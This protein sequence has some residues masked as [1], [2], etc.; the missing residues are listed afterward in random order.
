MPSFKKLTA[1]IAAAALN[2]TALFSLSSCGGSDGDDGKKGL[3]GWFT[4]VISSSPATLDPQTCTGD[5]A[6]Q[7]IANVFCGL[8]RRDDGGKVV[9][10]MAEKVSVSDDGLVYTFKLSENVKWYGKDD[11]SAECTAEDF[12]FAFRRLV[13]PAMRSVRASEYYCIK[14]AKEINTGK[15]TDLTQLGIEA[16]GKFEL[17]ITLCEPCSSLEQLLSAAPAMPCN[18]AYYELTEGQYGLV[19]DCIGSNGYFYVSRWHYDKW[20]K[21][22]NFIEL[23][24][25]PFNAEALETA[26]RGVTLMINVNGYESFLDGKTDVYCTAVPDEITRLSGR[27]AESPCPESVWGVVFNTRGA[28]ESTDL[29]IALGSF[30][31]GEFEGIYSSADCIVPDNASAGEYRSAAG[32][33]VKAQYSESELLE[34]GTRAVRELGDSA[35]TGMKLLIPEGTALRQGIGAVIQQW[36]KNFGV[37]CLIDEVPYPE[38]I[39]ALESGS[40][41]AAMVRLGGSDALTFLSAFSSTSQKNYGGVSSRKLDDILTGAHTAKDSGSAARYLLEAEQLILDSGWF[42]PL[43]FET[44]HIFVSSGVSGIVYDPSF[45]GYI[46]GRAVKK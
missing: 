14:N 9:P 25:N 36:Q 43:C 4:S 27:Y 23:K 37:Y 10:A 13:D 15:I 34:R 7:I 18:S 22:G 29:R 42:V 2:V 46:F 24:R 41:Q 21:D 12:V 1:Y 28:F 39:S 35:L 5:D 16:T 45:G 44:G 33:P 40:F 8:Y 19:G 20:V 26:P 38:Y 11:F 3:N 31:S 6:E 32:H 30:V 17:K